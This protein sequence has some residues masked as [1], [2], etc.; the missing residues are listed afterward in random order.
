[1]K[2]IVTGG[3]GQL[4][5]A[6]AALA[7]SVADQIVILGSREL[8]VTVP[9]QINGI[10]NQIRPD[11]VV[12]AG[13]YTAVDTAEK[14]PDQAFRVNTLGTR[15][16]AAACLNYDSKMVFLSSDY[17]FDGKQSLPYTEFD[18]PNPLNVYG[19]SKREGERMAARICPRHFIVRTSWLYG[20]GRNFVRTILKLAHERK[21]LTVVNDQTGTPTYTADLAQ[22]IMSIIRTDEFG[23]YHMSNSGYCTW[24]D[25]AKEIVRLA[26]FST[27]IQPVTT[28]EFA[29]AALRPRYS[30]LRNYMLELSSGDSFRCWQAALADFMKKDS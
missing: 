18:C 20:E 10:F 23:T 11:V 28:E 4:G 15:N 14:E 2:I 19:S 1:M 26:G 22:A 30:V 12:H 27:S 3:S 9:A 7:D 6:F 29:A 5:R 16:V 21:N 13:A 17:V 24:Y 8:D 25:F